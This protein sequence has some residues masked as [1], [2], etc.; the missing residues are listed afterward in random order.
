MSL[1]S[2]IR[3]LNKQRKADMIRLH[4]Y[5]HGKKETWKDAIKTGCIFFGAFVLIIGAMSLIVFIATILHMIGK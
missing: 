4:T 3:Q 5:L 2:D 1:I